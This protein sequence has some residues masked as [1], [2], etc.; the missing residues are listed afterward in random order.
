MY[1]MKK[2]N[3]SALKEQCGTDKLFF[4]EL[5]DIFKRSSLEG[6]AGLE[7]AYAKKD[8]ETFG[9]YAHKIISPCKH[10]EAEQLCILLKEIETKAE[11]NELTMER[12]GILLKDVK[13]KI[14]ELI[15]EM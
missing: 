1:S 2:Y 8:L 12:A 10:I 13:A 9:H 6:I 4:N 15:E 3:L 14:L 5:L 11:D 7:E